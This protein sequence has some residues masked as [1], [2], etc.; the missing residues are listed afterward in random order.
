M[1]ALGWRDSADT[2]Q[3]ESEE[4]KPWKTLYFKWNT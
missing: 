2:H 1:W 3:E 4:Q